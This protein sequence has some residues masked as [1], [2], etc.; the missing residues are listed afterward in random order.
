MSVRATSLVSASAAL[1]R[2]LGFVR[3][4][5]V[6]AALGAGPI[7]DALLVALRLP[8]L[9]RRALSEGAMIAGFAPLHARLAAREGEEAAARFAGR[10]ASALGL[11]LLAL[12]GLAH[13][14][15]GL[16]V[17]GV[18]AGLAGDA[19]ARA[20][21]ADLSRLAFPAIAFLGVAGLA[22]AA[23]AARGR[24]AALALAP[25]AM[26]A[27]LILALLV[28]PRLTA[29][30]GAIAAG[31]ALSTSVAG[32]VQLAIVAVAALRA[33]VVVW[34]WPRRDPELA[35][36]ARLAG[37]AF[38]VAAAPQLVPIA[39]MQVA[40]FTPGAVSWLHYAE[41][42]VHLPLSILA[43]VVGA[44][45]L[46]AIAA[47]R[48]AGDGPGAAKA[49]ADA[50]ALSALVA[51]PA[52]AALVVLAEPMARTLFERGAFTSADTAGT[53]A[54]IAGLAV[55]LPFAM[56]AKV[57]AQEA[58]AREALR[59]G[60]V[61]TAAALLAT[62]AACALLAPVLG[63]VGIGLG[64]SVGFVAQAVIT[65]LHARAAGGFALSAALAG[66]LARILAASLAMAGGLALAAPAVR[67][68]PD[69]IGLAL[70]CLGGL[71]AY[72]AACLLLGAVRREDLAAIRRG[73]QAS[74]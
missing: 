21:A 22:A 10:A 66:R 55:G 48:L 62:L 72:A 57:L 18:G 45:L 5:L 61:S 2:V 73:R 35:R 34:Q 60:L 40:S 39:A 13:L 6:A 8:N 26:N 12:V 38:V 9:A 7:A 42:L 17:L 30:P 19:A 41:R 43:V 25:L 16:L 46:P 1:S 63:P 44:V 31:V 49:T 27:I 68:L 15:A 32:A 65:A 24:F 70:L 11:A 74:Q 69:P 37:P 36:F 50:L 3:D 59:P 14:A 23:L 4:V 54:M 52:T 29:D 58:H 53:A 67:D 56:A 71:L 33:R 20:L 64:A 47:R 51:W 28:L